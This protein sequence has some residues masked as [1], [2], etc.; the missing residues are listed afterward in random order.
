MISQFISYLH[1][2]HAARTLC[3]LGA[4]VLL[5]C[6]PQNVLVA[7]GAFWNS[8]L[9][10][11]PN[12]SPYL[13]QW[14]SNPQI[15]TYSL[16]YTGKNPP[17]V[18]FRGVLTSNRFGQAAIVKGSTVH[19][20]GSSPWIF[21]NNQIL[22]ID[23]STYNGTFA[24]IIKKSGRLPEDD[25]TLCIT[26]LDQ[27]GNKLT[28][29]C[30]SFS[31][32]LPDQPQLVM[33][34]NNDTVIV[35]YP[36]FQWTP[37]FSAPGTTIRYAIRICEM[38]QGQHPDKA[39]TANIPQFQQIL[40][41]INMLVYPPNALPLEVGKQY[42]WQIQALDQNDA[43]ASVNDGKSEIWTF[44]YKK[45]AAQRTIPAP[46]ISGLTRVQGSLHYN[47]PGSSRPA[48]PLSN[49]DIKLLVEYVFH[50]NVG[51]PY[52]L[53]SG[54]YFIPYSDMGQEL[55]STKTD[56][57]GNFSFEFITSDSTRLIA[58]DTNIYIPNK[59]VTKGDLYRA[60]RVVI[61][62]PYYLSPTPDIMYKPKQLLDAGD[63]MAKA[64]RY[65]LVV[66]IWDPSQPG[67]HARN[68]TVASVY[69]STI[70]PDLPKDEGDP[71]DPRPQSGGWTLVARDSVS[72]GQVQFSCLVQNR[73]P[74]DAYKIEI[75]SP[76]WF[77][78]VS[79]SD[80]TIK[81]DGTPNPAYNYNSTDNAIFVE[82]YPVPHLYTEINPEYLSSY[83]TGHLAYKFPNG[84]CN[85]PL[86]G[87]RARLVLKY[88]LHK[89]GGGAVDVTS[90]VNRPD[91]NQELGVTTSDSTGK[92]GFYLTMSATFFDSMGVIA[93]NQT[94]KIGPT[95]FPTTYKGSLY[96]VARIIVDN[97]YYCSP[98]D[99]NPDYG[100]IEIQTLNFQDFGTLCCMVR[101]YQLHV[102]AKDKNTQNPLNN[103]FAYVLRLKHPATVPKD[104]CGG[105]NDTPKTKKY[106]L[107]TFDIV[108]KGVTTIDPSTNQ[109]GTITFT[110]L[111]KNDIS[112]TQDKYFILL[113]SDP[114]GLYNYKT[115]WEPFTFNCNG[116]QAVYNE[117]YQINPPY[118]YTMS[119]E[120]EPLPPYIA[121]TIIR[122]DSKLPAPNI[123]VYLSDGSTSWNKT[124]DTAGYIQ[125]DNLPENPNGPDRKLY[126]YCHSIGF[127]D[128]TLNT[129][130]LTKG[131]K[132]V[133]DQITI[134][135]AGSISG[136][137]VDETGQPV[138]AYI[139]IQG[140]A[141]VETECD[142]YQMTTLGGSQHGYSAK[143][144]TCTKFGFTLPAPTGTQT[145][146]IEPVDHD[147]YIMSDTSLFI[148]KQDQNVGK[149]T[150]YRK[151]HR[152]DV[153]VNS[154]AKGPNNS[155][156]FW[157]KG[158]RIEF[159]NLTGVAPQT[160]DV[161]GHA[162]F[163]FQNDAKSFKIRVRGP[164]DQDYETQFASVA[165]SCTKG[166]HEVG[167][168]LPVAGHVTGKVFVGKDQE[169]EGAHVFMAQE[170]SG[171]T[172][173]VDTTTTIEGVFTLRNVPLGIHTFYA[174]KGGT[175]GDSAQI[176]VNEDGIKIYV[177][178]PSM[179]AQQGKPSPK[180][181]WMAI[182]SLKFHLTV[183]NDMDVTRLLDLPV[184]ITKLLPQPGKKA[185]ISGRFIALPTNKQFEIDT[186]K[187]FSFFDIVIVPG[188]KL[189]SNNIPIAQPE[190][191]YVPLDVKTIEIAKILQAF[192]GTVTGNG[193]TGTL[194]VEDVKKNGSGVLRGK[195]AIY[196]GSFSTGGAVSFPKDSIGLILPGTGSMNERMMV[197]V[198]AAAES[199]LAS[200]PDGFN[201]VD[202]GGIALRYSLHTFENSAVADSNAS[203]AT[204]GVLNLATHLHT[205]IPTITPSD[206][207]LDIG[208]IAVTPNA[209]QAVQ[210]TNEITAQ[211]EKWQLVSSDWSFTSSG[212]V[213]HSGTIK[214]GIVD[215]PF[216]K[217]LP[218]TPT[219]LET[220]KSSFDLKN[221]TLGGVVPLVISGDA[222]FVYNPYAGIDDP[223]GH[224]SL[225]VIPKSGMSECA[226]INTLPGMSPGDKI[227]FGSFYVLSNGETGFATDPNAPPFTLY[228]VASFT[229]VKI[230][231]YPNRV[232]IPGSLDLHIPLDG[233][234]KTTSID[235]Y[236]DASNNIAFAF[237]PINFKFDTKGVHVEIPGN[238]SNPQTLDEKGFIAKATISEAGKYSFT[239]HLYRT[240]DST[241][242][243]IDP[244]Q[245]LD[246][247]ANSSSK[248]TAIAGNMHVESGSW[249]NLWFA[250]D[251]T[252]TEGAT[253]RLTFKV[254]G[255]IV[256]D[257]QQ[258]GVKNIPSPFGNISFTYDFV[259]HRL[260]GTVDF[261]QGID[262]GPAQVSGMGEVLID[263]GG[264]YFLAGANLKLAGF[265]GQAAVVFGNYPMTDHMKNLFGQFSWIYQHKGSFPTA[266]PVQ[267][268]GFFGEGELQLPIIPNLDFDFLI[269]TGELYVNIGGDLSMGMNFDQ[270]ASYSMGVNVF[271]EAGAGI[272]GSIG[273]ACAGLKAFATVIAGYGGQIST[274]GDWFV[275][276]DASI[277]LC[278]S[279]YAGWGVCDSDCDGTFCD[280]HE[281]GGCITLGLKAHLG[282]DGKS[283]TPYIK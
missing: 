18:T 249:T 12:P 167:V 204:D 46:Q 156:L 255:E 62:S 256:A 33:P 270:G 217:D 67:G 171:E 36:T 280:K 160:T 228:N 114:K 248:L 71:L 188:S 191:G 154:I 218:V 39:L 252:G 49:I 60:G 136:E 103:I 90:Y 115:Y 68:G 110:N 106:G 229:P 69:R 274:S 196:A 165:D 176:E 37:V 268:K 4:M 236:K 53:R 181:F 265:G 92:V 133:L 276:G 258:V 95:E 148:F 22:N 9:V 107:Y 42:A 27:L 28:E 253:G 162:Y 130:R 164:A 239:I 132:Q 101:S 52:V 84:S 187:G 183:Y 93:T 260:L 29:A 113:E 55:A 13:S 222:S 262:L 24:G 240:T 145:V 199:D 163:V 121:A 241:S 243:W 96:R 246:I 214:T 66:Q 78:M 273:I 200:V 261:S 266:F 247:A 281:A 149:L 8:S 224:W 170:G 211:L 30:A 174:V 21:H 125:F 221:M 100:D 16:F 5:V 205:N 17:A 44:I 166:W 213:L 161:G 54:F 244:G 85:K 58:K 230:V 19:P 238:A 184:E 34:Q 89:N 122:S 112:N 131:Q 251:M 226:M 139:G 45:L 61:S 108:A 193:T 231:V 189:N 201:I 232:N 128:S 206:I 117:E 143:V 41:N 216:N 64:R 142:N 80:L 277:S 173:P 215:V 118:T 26:A 279:A 48:Q 179:G 259:N 155:Q 203:F 157:V 70:Y 109:K 141:K 38:L 88:I 63:L 144:Y 271:G 159:L 269:V 10:I 272:G 283:I 40:T 81:F 99:G 254:Y 47:W 153:R 185:K 175:I 104:E 3:I 242:L 105:Y 2:T 20:S 135:P 102:V 140:G 245:S 14:Q 82:E 250:G 35:T 146:S 123:V 7:Q 65:D 263:N 147:K 98:G 87:V 31:I 192:N 127:R 275:E 237:D 194:Q 207:N 227:S 97:P 220:E 202:I 129:L 177:R 180:P 111:V 75:K 57:S 158:A 74:G 282:S 59:G 182:D 1:K 116:D 257:N 94:F 124:T 210:S 51:L 25:Y 195:V 190:A 73:K 11:M 86:G 278:G 267:I 120:L 150:A 126:V 172:E 186:S 72:S 235:Y 23:Q 169:V 6:L 198:V 208:V 134:F 234:G 32:I 197:P 151:L 223:K 168:Y 119:R 178:P 225:T 212:F 43:P 137:V 76:G 56:G 219:K 15:V 83:M 91:G 209:V 77:P 50:P 264:W 79:Y 233:G 138:D 152:I